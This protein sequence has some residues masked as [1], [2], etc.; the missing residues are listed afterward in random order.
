MPHFLKMY[1]NR[2]TIIH[3]AKSGC[4][5]NFL[6]NFILAN[7]RKRYFDCW[8]QSS[9]QYTCGRMKVRLVDGLRVERE[10]MTGWAQ[11]GFTTISVSRT[12]WISISHAGAG[13][14]GS[15]FLNGAQEVRLCS[16]VID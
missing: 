6:E 2:F 11:G 15:S 7:F 16:L 12:S 10:G 14:M 4:G 3:F 8:G 13:H 9:S 5:R 1:Q